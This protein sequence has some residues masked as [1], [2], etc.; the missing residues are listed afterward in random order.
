MYKSNRQNSAKYAWYQKV[1][2]GSRNKH[3][4]I[5]KFLQMKALSNSLSNFLIFE[6]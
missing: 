3:I 5:F 1:E 2:D 4:F 6:V